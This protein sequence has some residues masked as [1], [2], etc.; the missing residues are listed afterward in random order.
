MLKPATDAEAVG[1]TLAVI[2]RAWLE[3]R[4][5]EL[6]PLIHESFV[7]VFPGFAGRSNGKEAA[8]AGFEDFCQHATVRAFHEAAHQCDVVGHTGVASFTFDMTYDRDGQAYRSTGRD[9]WVFEQI[10]GAWLAVW[11]TMLDLTDTPLGA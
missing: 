4:P 9:V 11:R 10:R 3:R 8:I 5:R 1:Q 2:N 7:M 6:G